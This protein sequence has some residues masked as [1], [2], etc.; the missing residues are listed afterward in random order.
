M[1]VYMYV[2]VKL[3]SLFG[4]LTTFFWVFRKCYGLCDQVLLVVMPWIK[5]QL[6]FRNMHV[7]NPILS[8]IFNLLEALTNLGLDP[9][10]LFIECEGDHNVQR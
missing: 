8:K 4:K 6:V 2:F 5:Y 10:Y 3:S 1:L 7:L 9:Y